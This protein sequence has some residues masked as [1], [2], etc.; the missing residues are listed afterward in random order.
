MIQGLFLLLH[1]SDYFMLPINIFRSDVCH[2][3]S[4]LN[5]RKA[6]GP[7]G[8]PAIVLRKGSFTFTTSACATCVRRE[9]VEKRA[10]RVK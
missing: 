2:A 1:P 8:V 3:L 10:R 6:C 4:G 7:D 9:V 5:P